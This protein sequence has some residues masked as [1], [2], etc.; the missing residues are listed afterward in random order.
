MDIHNKERKVKRNLANLQLNEGISKA[1]K[2]NIEGF[3]EYLEAEG[4]GYAKIDRYLTSIKMI[5]LA[6]NFDLVKIN[7]DRLNK[8]KS[9]IRKSEIGRGKEL[10]IYTQIE[11]LS[12][13]KKFL[14]WK[15]KE[16]LVSQI[17]TYIPK[18]KRDKLLPKGEELLTKEEILTMINHC[19]NKRDRAL[20]SLLFSLG[21]AR[22]GEALNVKISDLKFHDN[23]DYVLVTLEG[24]TGRRTVPMEFCLPY[25][26]DWLNEHP[27]K[28]DRRAYLFV[29]LEG[30]R[31]YPMIYES[32]RKV[33]KVASD[34][35]G[36]KDKLIRP[37]AVRHAIAS[38]KCHEWSSADMNYFFG[39]VQGSKMAGIYQNLNG[40]VMH[41]A[42]RKR[43]GLDKDKKDDRNNIQC[44]RCKA[45][46]P[47]DNPFC[48]KC[49]FPLSQKTIEEDILLDKLLNIA[50]RKPAF[51][52]LILEASREL[53]EEK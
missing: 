35:A 12:G 49:H 7:E 18:A 46:N 15:K 53:K 22:I 24:K 25:I 36:I 8:L 23:E 10:S 37:H 50:S 48:M 33:L 39:W 43:R 2:L 1:N 44:P 42:Y 31:N 13:L 47:L 45:I 51:R 34:R 5:A 40:E 27:L 6:V 9:L 20:I 16:D 14:K 3:V 29:N 38:I 41:Q 26:K 4:I 52:K 30:K 11:Y 19:K 21:G 17:K 28:Q 32:A